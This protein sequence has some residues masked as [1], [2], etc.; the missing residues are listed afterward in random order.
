MGTWH[1]LSISVKYQYLPE[2]LSLV[3]NTT[4]TS[5]GVGEEMALNGQ[6]NGDIRTTMSR[7]KALSGALCTSNLPG[8][9]KFSL[10]LP[11]HN[12]QELRR[13]DQGQP[14]TGG[15]LGA[16]ILASVVARAEKSARP[17]SH[18]AKQI[19]PQRSS[20]HYRLHLPFRRY[21]TLRQE[22]YIQPPILAWM[23]VAASPPL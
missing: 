10:T 15:K 6:Q 11:P 17:L 7:D 9:R 4:R 20:R 16:L 3:Y 19:P 21:P 1:D 18:T 13:E 23:P 12:G 2:L 14:V 22:R 8:E 5:Y